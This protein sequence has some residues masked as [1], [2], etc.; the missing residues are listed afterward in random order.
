MHLEPLV[1]FFFFFCPGLET[2]L[3]PWFFFFFF[4]L[5]QGL[6][7]VSGLFF[8]FLSFYFPLFYF[9]FTGPERHSQSPFHLFYFFIFL[10]HRARDMSRALFSSFFII[11]FSSWAL[12]FIF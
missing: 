2:H 10:L 9:Y 1:F 12:V 11:L 3:G 8:I 7:C 6:R 4:S 5:P